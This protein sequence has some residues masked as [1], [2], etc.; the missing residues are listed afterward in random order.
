M[1]GIIDRY[2]MGTLLRLHPLE[3]E[4]VVVVKRSTVVLRTVRV[5]HAEELLHKSAAAPAKS[6]DWCMSTPVQCATSPSSIPGQRG[7]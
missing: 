4:V 1:Y 3:R 6:F 5:L 2:V 7:A